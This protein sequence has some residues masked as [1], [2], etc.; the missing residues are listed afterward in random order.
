MFQRRDEGN[1]ATLEDHIFTKHELFFC[2]C[3]VV[4]CNSWGPERWGPEHVPA[5]FLALPQDQPR[6]TRSGMGP[7]SAFCTSRDPL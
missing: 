7:T 1:Y 5:A 6:K 2:S 3:Q 4:E